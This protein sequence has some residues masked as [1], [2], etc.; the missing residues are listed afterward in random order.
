MQPLF[1]LRLGFR[2]VLVEQL[3]GLGGGVAVEGVLELCK[4][5]GDFQAEVENLALALEEDVF[6]PST[7]L[8]AI[9]V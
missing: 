5:G 8:L 3:E 2:A 7:A 6:W 9:T 4:G 1:L